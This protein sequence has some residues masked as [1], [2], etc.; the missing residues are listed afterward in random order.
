MKVDRLNS[1]PYQVKDVKKLLGIDKNKLFYWIKTHRLLKPEIEE[2]KGTGTK[3]KFSLKNLLELAVIKEML[4]FGFDLK[5][6]KK[7]KRNIDKYRE[8]N[9]NIYNILLKDENRE[10]R[11]LYIYKSK[12]RIFL[13][14]KQ[15]I[16]AVDYDIGPIAY[17]EPSEWDENMNLRRP[18]SYV[19]VLLRIGMVANDLIN[20]LEE[21]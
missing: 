10:G 14:L 16:E 20:K 21:Y 6:I 4:N 1:K 13:Y 17:P 9:E 5:S 7:I 12:N 8:N 19:C 11:D 18:P 3:V 2:A 15:I